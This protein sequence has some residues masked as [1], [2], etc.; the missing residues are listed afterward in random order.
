MTN[1]KCIHQFHYILCCATASPTPLAV[2][3]S[4]TLALAL[5]VK[6]LLT[7]HCSYHMLCVICE[8]AQFSYG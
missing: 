5:D 8:S 1:A 3:S 6:S 2:K 4:H 7:Y